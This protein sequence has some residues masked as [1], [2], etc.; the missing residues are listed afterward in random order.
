MDGEQARPQ[1]HEDTQA[2]GAEA[3]ADGAG[4]DDYQAALKA[5]DVRIAE[6][7]GKVAVNLNLKLPQFR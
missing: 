7:E 1:G 5:K 4:G 3:V 2:D 6:L